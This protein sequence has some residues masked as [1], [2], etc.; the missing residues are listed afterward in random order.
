MLFF[1]HLGMG[2]PIVLHCVVNQ[3]HTSSPHFSSF[4]K[5]NPIVISSRFSFECTSVVSLT[6][7]FIHS[8]FSQPQKSLHS[9]YLIQKP[10]HGAPTSTSFPSTLCPHWL[11]HIT[12]GHLFLYLYTHPK[13]FFIN[14]KN[15]LFPEFTYLFIVTFG[16]LLPFF[17]KRNPYHPWLGHSL[18]YT[19]VDIIHIL[20]VYHRKL[21]SA[22]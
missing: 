6:L 9:I 13:L 4:T 2:V 5:W 14:Y 18:S 12:L 19:P 21:T 8:Q 22:L 11:N 20:Q 15:P 17:G 1:N 7:H 10:S 16:D 3:P